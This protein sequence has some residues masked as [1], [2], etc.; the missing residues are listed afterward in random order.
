MPLSAG[1]PELPDGY[2]V[3]E[4]SELTAGG[5]PLLEAGIEVPDD[6]LFKSL[7]SIEEAVFA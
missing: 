6:P 3:G 2:T 5:L 7:D 4:G 1:V